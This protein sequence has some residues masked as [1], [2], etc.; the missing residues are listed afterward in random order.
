MQQ[1]ST[2]LPFDPPRYTYDD[3]KNWSDEWELIDGYPYSLMPSAKRK[4]QRFATQF[5]WIVKNILAG[6]S[7][8][9]EV[10]SEFDWIINEETVVRPDCM[11]VCGAFE[12]DWLTFPPT[13]IVE[14]GSASTYMKDRN[15]KYKLYEMNAVKYY[16]LAD[17]EKQRVDSYEWIDG[18]FQPKQD[19]TFRL[20]EECEVKID[21][22]KMWG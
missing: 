2:R 16:L 14:I 15:L 8:D 21:F 17:T 10:F 19:N 22:E 9:C 4:H 6:K 1:K 11:I 5:I 13:L 3:Y 7:C 12:T 18:S 20:S